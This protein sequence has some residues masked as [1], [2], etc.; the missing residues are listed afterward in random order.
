MDYLNTFVAK[1]VSL[2]AGRKSFAVEKDLYTTLVVQAP[3]C[4]IYKQI[5]FVQVLSDFYHMQ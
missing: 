5:W 2:S 4:A 3:P 1:I